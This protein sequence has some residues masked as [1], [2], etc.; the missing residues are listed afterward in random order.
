MHIHPQIGVAAEQVCP[1]LT[2]DFRALHRV[3][4]IRTLGFHFE[5]PHAAELAAQVGF[6]RLADCAKLFGAGDSAAEFDDAEH[7]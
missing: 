2:A 1:D 7:L 6:G 3:F 5:C 4:L